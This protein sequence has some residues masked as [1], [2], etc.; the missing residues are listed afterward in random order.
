[1]KTK[2]LL[3]VT[4]IICLNNFCF[5]MEIDELRQIIKAMES[6]YIDI[7]IDYTWDQNPPMTQ[8]DVA[9]TGSLIPIGKRHQTFMTAR[10]FSERSLSSEKVKLMDEHGISFDSETKE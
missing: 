6:A 4:L 2:I 1:M 8:E 10:P 9:G 5:S 7:S 3:I